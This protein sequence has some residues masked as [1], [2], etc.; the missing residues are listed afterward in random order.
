MKAPF[1]S[2][3]GAAT[4]LL[5]LSVTAATRPSFV[6]AMADDQG[7]GDM[8]YNGH[9]VVRTPVFDEMARTGLRL[10]RFYAAAP[11]CSPTRGSVLTGRTPNRFGCFKWG[12]TLRPA[13]VTIAER[14][15]EAGYRTGHFG[16]W[17]LGSL[18]PDS[19][20]SPGASGFDEWVSSPN[21][22]DLDPWMARNGKAQKTTG[23]GSMVTVDAALDFIRRAAT[24]QAPFLA[25][26]WFGSPHNPHLG[27]PDDL[28]LYRDQ[29]ARQQRFLAE[30]TAMDR[31]MGRLRAGLREAGVADN[32]VLWYCSDNGAI[33]EGSTGGLRGGKARIYE[34]GL[35]VPALIE[36]PRVIRR[37]RTS[38]LPCGTVDIFPTVLE[39]AELAPGANRPLDGVSLARLLAGDLPERPKPMGFWDYPIPGRAVR[40]SDLLATLAAEQA[41]DQVRSAAEVEPIPPAQFR[42]DYPPDRFPGHAAW[43]DGAWKLHRIESDDD[44]VRWELYD[45]KADPREADDR[46]PS[47][48]PRA[49]RMQAALEAWLRSVVHSLNGGDDA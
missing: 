17:H 22:F 43:I 25:V 37:P 16:K 24:A 30:I 23:E 45:L 48:A 47:E 1:R 12:Y 32:T 49:A 9:P 18:R 27:G 20:V 39:L 13:E 28:A 41:S 19:P 46:F 31:A 4:L 3:A 2:L 7:W 5:G 15:R 44:P 11:V 6:L 33:P 36:W 29:P 42:R 26:V 14:L 34:G 40:S 8:A 21:F 38:A 35:R 10:D